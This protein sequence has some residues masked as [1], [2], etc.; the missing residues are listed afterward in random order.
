MTQVGV[1]LASLP[2]AAAH[3]LH[4]E[5]IQSCI[6]SDCL[7]ADYYC[8]YSENADL[9]CQLMMLQAACIES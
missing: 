3:I 7:D 9:A 6:Y 1:F 8:G 4:T 2:Q 5:V